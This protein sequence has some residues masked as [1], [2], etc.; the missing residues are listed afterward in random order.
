MSTSEKKILLDSRILCDL[1]LLLVDAY[2]P[3]PGFM[4]KDEYYNV[5][6][7]MTYLDSKREK[8]VWTLPIVL[9]VSGKKAQCLNIGDNVILTDYTNLPLA[10]MTLIDIY[11]ADLNAEMHH[12]YRDENHPYMKYLRS[13]EYSYDGEIYYLGGKV[14]ASNNSI[15]HFD[16]EDLRLT[17]GQVKA[18]FEKRGWTNVVAFQTRNPMHRCHYALTQYA[19]GEL[20]SEFPDQKEKCG[21]LVQPAVGMSQTCDVD[22]LT[23][24]KCYRE[25]IKKYPVGT[26]MLALVP[27]NMRMAGPR[28]AVQHAIVR[29]N[30]GAT[31]FVVGRG[32]A[33][34]SCK[35]S[36]GENFYQPYEAQELVQSVCSKI[37]ISMIKSKA[38]V[39]VQELDQYIQIDQVPQDMTVKNLSGT[40]LRELLRTG[41]DIPEWFTFPEI[42]KILIGEQQE[43]SK[44]GL[45]L[46][47]EGLSGSGKTTL[48]NYIKLWI[49][50]TYNRKVTFL[51]GDVVR[52]HLSKGLG[53][54]KEDRSTNV[55]RV[56]FVA[57]E[58]VKHGGIVICANICPYENDREYN[59]EVVSNNG[60]YVEIY[61]DTDLTECEHRDVK[62][63]YRLAREGKIKGFTGIS[64][65]FENPENIE[66]HLVNNNGRLDHNLRIIK[67]YI[68][69]F[70]S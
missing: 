51:D 25:I 43:Q 6:E 4:T 1:E 18:E 14:T 24:T 2:Q 59:R 20:V 15:P 42:S 29:K 10:N 21:L 33:E 61:V 8:H 5:L 69:Q 50:S 44:P 3:L 45:C 46:Y 26:A 49:E 54:S 30:Y 60:K 32:H 36:N 55:R 52:Q 41:K 67:E 57:S 35:M 58:I 27:L 16:N 22:H 37:G 40:Q 38:L 31:H 53:F 70:L 48:A 64:D 12:I 65:P 39:Y 47:F 17:T 28:E 68:S 9:P 7:N 23:R 34:P 63:L 62:G 56:G 13:L 66:L 11:P 19:Y